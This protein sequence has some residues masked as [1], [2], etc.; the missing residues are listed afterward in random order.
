MENVP[1]ILSMKT[2]NNDKVLDIILQEFLNIG[3][4]VEYKILHAADFGVPQ[5]RK[6]VIFIGKP[7]E[8]QISLSHP[9]P[10]LSSS[11]H[12]PVRT[13]LEDRDHIPASYFLSEKALNG[14]RIKKEKMK[15][16]GHGFGAQFLDLN[17]TCYTIPARYYKDGYDALLR[18]EENCV[19][20]LTEKEVARIQTFPETYHFVGNKKEIFMQIGNAV[21]CLL[22]YHIGLHSIKLL[23]E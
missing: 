12:I 4:Q 1:G 17:R 23:S 9:Q 10:V 5:M 11:E 15:E 18:Y 3:Y 20:R 13:I 14:I 22:A 21:P 8:S 16:K 7:I 19:R 2:I 6:R